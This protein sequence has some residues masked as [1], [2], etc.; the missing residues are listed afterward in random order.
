[1]YNVQYIYIYVIPAV[2]ILDEGMDLLVPRQADD[3][4]PQP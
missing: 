3:L 1:M 4:T 2:C